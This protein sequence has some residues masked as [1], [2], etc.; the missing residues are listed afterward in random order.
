MGK[1]DLKVQTWKFSFVSD[2]FGLCSL[3]GALLKVSE[4]IRFLPGM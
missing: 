3:S 4:Q 1:L 2:I